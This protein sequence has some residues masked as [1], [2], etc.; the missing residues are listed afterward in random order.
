MG[1]ARGDFT[2]ILVQKGIIG[3]DQIAEAKALQAQTGMK[4]GDERFY[5]YIHNYGFGQQTGIELPGETR[6]MAKPANR[7]SKVSIGAISIVRRG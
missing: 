6:G 7:W 5:S 4:L 2:E 1:K 3:S